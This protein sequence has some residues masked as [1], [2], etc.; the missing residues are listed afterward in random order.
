[1]FLNKRSPCNEKPV[2][3]NKEKPPLTETREKPKHLLLSDVFFEVPAP[4]L[5]SG[6][7]TVLHSE[8]ITPQWREY[9]LEA[10]WR[11]ETDCCALPKGKCAYHI[12]IARKDG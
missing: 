7:F 5:A 11:E 3:C 8:D 2:Y 9:Y 10:L 12:V 4:L 6:G 1:M